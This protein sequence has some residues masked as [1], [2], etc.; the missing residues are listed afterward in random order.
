MS[1]RLVML[2]GTLC[3]QRLFA[4]VARRLRPGIAVRVARWPELL[5]R[6]APPWWTS[7]ESISLLGFSLGGIWALQQLEGLHGQASPVPIE[8]LALVGSNA[9]PAGSSHRKRALQQQRLLRRRGV[10]AVARAAK[11][12]YFARRPASWQLRL[13]VDMARRTR[14]ATARKQIQLAAQRPDGLHAFA[15][16][17]GPVAVLSG[18]QDRLCPPVQQQRLRAARDD[19]FAVAWPGCGH[20]IPL[21]APGRLAQAI[22]RW[23]AQDLTPGTQ[24]CQACT[25]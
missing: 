10:A 15:S 5:G 17:P 18:A 9:E 21:E 14:V 7:G 11:G 13:V 2:P 19:A 1:T 16:F 24:S 22:R 3:D 6:R 25:P 12:H 4:A 8:R 23:L 20:M